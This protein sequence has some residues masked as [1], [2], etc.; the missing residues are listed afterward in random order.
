MAFVETLEISK[1]TAFLSNELLHVYSCAS[2]HK[3]AL[4]STYSRHSPVSLISPFLCQKSR[5]S[6]FAIFLS[7][8]LLS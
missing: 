5:V 3:L 6:F 7:F 4:I 8:N 2:V 1:C